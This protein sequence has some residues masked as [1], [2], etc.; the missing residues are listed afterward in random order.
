MHRRS[1]N[2]IEHMLQVGAETGTVRV[3][4]HKCRW[5]RSFGRRAT[6]ENS[7]ALP[8][9]PQFPKNMACPL[10]ANFHC[11]ALGIGVRMLMSGALIA[12]MSVMTYA[13]THESKRQAARVATWRGKDTA[14]WAG[15]AP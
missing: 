5:N 3:S 14:V 9:K 4:L 7:L 8:S 10:P 1:V 11:E 2:G 13:L 6:Q 12:S 15:I